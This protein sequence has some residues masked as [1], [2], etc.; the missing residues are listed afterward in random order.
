M[1]EQGGRYQR[2]MSGM[3]GALVVTLVAIGGFV[4]FRALNRDN[5]EVRPEPVDYLGSVRYIQKAGDTVAYPSV[6]PSRW[7]CT[8]AGYDPGRVRAWEMGVLTEDDTF[9]GLREEDASVEGLV[10]EFVDEDATE[11]RPVELESALAE[12]WR[13]FTDRGG[14][15][16]V[17]AEIGDEALLVYGNATRQEINDFAATLVTSPVE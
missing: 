12:S 9:V 10:H 5:L 16:A 11:G 6:L 17:A 4:A 7:V 8:G 15:Y 1:S 3:V 13:T 2:S 14:D